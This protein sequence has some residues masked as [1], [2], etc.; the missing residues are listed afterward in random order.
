[1]NKKWL[2]KSVPAAEEIERLKQELH[3]DSI[4]ATLLLQKGITTKP[5]AES[6]LRPKMEEIHDPFEMK[7]MKEAIE[8]INQA[9]SSN[10]KILLFG[11]Y[12]V[13]GTTAVALVYL[14][15]IPYYQSIS[16]YIPDR[17]TEG[18]GISKQG[19]DFAIQEGYSLI[20]ALDCGIKSID[21]VDYA[22]QNSVDFIICD[23]HQPGPII[24]DC[25]VLDPKRL[26][27]PYPFKELCGCGVGFKVMQALYTTNKWEE[28]T[29]FNQLDLVAISIGADIVPVI[30]EN[31]IL[32]YHGMKKL[33]ENPRVAFQ[34]LITLAKKNF[35][36]TL[37]D[38]VFII[39]PRINAAGRLRSGKYAVELMIST[40]RTEMNQLAQDIHLDNQNRRILD[41]EITQEALKIIELDS[42]SSIKKST[43][44]YQP[45]WHKGVVGIVASR[46]IET[47][48]K[49]T[50]VLTKSNGLITGSARS[51]EDF[52][53]YEAI[54][55]CSHLLEQFGGHK[56]AAGLTLKEENLQKFVVLFEEVTQEKLQN[57]TIYP[58]QIIDAEIA[59]NELFLPNE[60][61]LKIP[62][63]KKI[64]DHF[65]PFGPGNMKP[66]FVSENVYTKNLRLLN[67]AHL[68]LT[69]VQ[70]NHD[71]AM[72]AIGFNMADKEILVADGLPF[73]LAYTLETNVFREKETLQLNLKDIREI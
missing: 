2:L 10:E 62:R 58:T 50:I 37:T 49:P 46:L 29:L 61:R 7:D 53:L 60:N 22:K 21:L 55:A 25:I 6:F 36:L 56:H 17:Y 23:H 14:S 71:L 8:R 26:D 42:N 72:E 18:Y 24:P 41:Q 64:I 73:Q 3:V 34:E 57:K 48:Y 12:D 69:V 40:N 32:A 65:E 45:H 47:H 59:F 52:D 54:D 44:V 1:M 15:L 16:F 20:I 5:E 33:N 35:P 43:V 66:V 19:I 39:A 30:G 51:I 68:K 28:G 11:D 9:I 67:D 31:R 70:P 38:V 63:F 27:C 13:D 4:V